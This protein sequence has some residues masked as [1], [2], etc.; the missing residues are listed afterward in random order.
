MQSSFGKRCCTYNT[1][2]L[3]LYEH[4]PIS[5]KEN[6]HSEKNLV[7]LVI[8][9]FDVD[10]GCIKELLIDPESIL[11]PWNSDTIGYQN[12][13]LRNRAT[14][15]FSNHRSKMLRYRTTSVLSFQAYP[16]KGCPTS[17]SGMS[18]CCRRRSTIPVPS[19]WTSQTFVLKN[20]ETCF[21]CAWTKRSLNPCRQSYWSGKIYAIN[22]RWD[23]D[24]LY[25]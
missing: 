18:G 1:H 20:S 22:L 8:C 2:W 5:M 17:L 6:I 19:R 14:R 23:N 12:H 11:S 13:Q 24:L 15:V 25:Q 4:S 9:H 21:L 7:D 3:P 16:F 10:K